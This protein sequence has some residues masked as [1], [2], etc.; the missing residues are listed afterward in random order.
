MDTF[1]CSSWYYLRYTS[2]EAKDRPFRKEDVDYWMPVDQYIGGVEHA[3]LHLLYSRFFTKVLNDLGLVD[4]R[5]PF[6]NLFAQGMITKGG[7]KMSKSK[8]NTVSPREIINRFGADTVRVFILFAGPPELDM[9]WSD[10]GVEGAFRFLNRVWRTVGRVIEF[11]TQEIEID[12]GRMEALE[13]KVHQTI[14]RVTRDIREKFHFNTAIS[15]LMELLNEMIDYVRF[16]EEKGASFEEKEIL[17]F[18]SRTL[19]SLLNPIAP[20]LSEELWQLLGEK[21]LLSTESWPVYQKEKMYEEEV[22]VI[23]QINGRVRSKVVVSRGSSKEEVL[24]LA[25]QDEK[26]KSWLNHGEIKKSIYVPD[27]LINLVVG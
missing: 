22:E 6:S 18:A 7:V 4:F 19:V 8:G 15:S 14:F 10:Q 16:L 24:A 27:K 26:V 12:E 11:P 5:E 21:D 25:L 13:R 9:E 17:V 3:I 1:V 23:V 20:H 2:P